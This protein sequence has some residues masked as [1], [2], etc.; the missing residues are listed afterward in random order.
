MLP[1]SQ[2]LKICTWMPS[3]RSCRTGPA[4]ERHARIDQWPPR[5]ENAGPV[6]LHLGYA[7]G[8]LES[9]Y[10]DV[11]RRPQGLRAL[12]RNWARCWPRSPA[13]KAR[14]SS[15]CFVRLEAAVKVAYEGEPFID[16]VNDGPDYSIGVL[17]VSRGRTGRLRR[18]EA[19]DVIVAD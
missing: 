1:R 6:L 19:R 7:K 18:S 15:S 10:G 3:V 13:I 5:N 8:L 9:G 12:C 4:V 2:P 11:T 16:E 14:P 17:C